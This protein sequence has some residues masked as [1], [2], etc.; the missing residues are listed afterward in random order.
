MT[1]ELED[2]G[3]LEFAENADPRLP[4][5]LVLDCSTSMTDVRE[6][7]ERSPLEALNGGLDRLVTALHSDPLARKRAE[8]SFIAYGSEVSPATPFTTVDALVLPELREMGVTSS[9]AALTEALDAIEA[10]KSEYKSAGIQYFKPLVLWVTDGLS[11]DDTS[12]VSRKIAEGTEKKKLTLFPVAVE[13]ADMEA[14]EKTAGKKALKLQG[15]KF[16]E[17]F[18][19][20]SASAASVSA[21]QPGDKV[22]APAP[23]GWAEL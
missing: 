14:M 15:V 4:M 8:V 22:A 11:T 3:D 6:G 17:L 1:D 7:E 18:L 13:G 16:E 12:D 23:D 10:R 20:L 2:F 21:S 9:G 19:W 5:V